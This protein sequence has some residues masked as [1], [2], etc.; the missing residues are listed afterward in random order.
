MKCT[1]CNAELE[2]NDNFCS[3]CGEWTAKGYNFLKEESNIAVINKGGVVKQNK[4]LATLT[5]ILS[6]GIIL[7][8]GML[9][10]QGKDLF[11]PLIYLKKHLFF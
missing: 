11:K 8:V 1:K 3:Q 4:R 9:L 7:F 5:T 10:I 2:E 6:L